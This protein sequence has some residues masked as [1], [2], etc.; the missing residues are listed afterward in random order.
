MDTTSLTRGLGINLPAEQGLSARTFS[1]AQW[2]RLLL[3][4]PNSGGRLIVLT[5]VAYYLTIICYILFS[6]QVVELVCGGSVINGA[7]PVQF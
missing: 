6:D 2:R 5:C 7:Y 3:I 1:K 4:H